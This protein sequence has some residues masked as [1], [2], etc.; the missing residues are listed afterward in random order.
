MLRVTMLFCSTVR[1][2]RSYLKNPATAQPQYHRPPDPEHYSS[3]YTNINLLTSYSQPLET[4]RGS[5][6]D[7]GPLW[8]ADA[9][10]V[11][12][13]VTCFRS[14]CS[15]VAEDGFEGVEVHLP[16]GLITGRVNRIFVL[17][18]APEGSRANH[19]GKYEQRNQ[20]A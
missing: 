6:F 3:L 15:W 20:Q 5:S 1:L 11:R 14:P 19:R 8:T 12:T 2:L 7:E 16:S 4:S 9:P 13:S 10:H 18:A 17:L